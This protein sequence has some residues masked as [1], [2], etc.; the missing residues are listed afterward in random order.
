MRPGGTQGAAAAHGSGDGNGTG[1]GAD[2]ARREPALGSATRDEGTTRRS[3]Y[4]QPVIK[5]PVWAP[6]IPWYFF[7][8]GLG[9]ASGGLAYLAG[10]RGSETLA[11]RAWTIALAALSVSPVL[12]I[13][14]LGRPERFLHM[15][16]MFKVTSPMS[17]G[18]W[19][20]AGSGA[21]TAL[22]ALNV[23]TGRLGRLARVGRPAAAALG[24]PLATYTGALLAQTA[25]PAW[26]EA[27]RELPALFAAGAA[28]S[29]GAAATVLTPVAH[30]RPARRLALLGAATELMLVP[31]MERRLG[32][33]AE[34]YHDGPAGSYS[35]AAR[36]LTA[37]GAL[38][39]ATRAHRGRAAAM[40][41]GTLV[42]AG[43]V[44]ERWSVFKAG[45][46]SA[47]DPKYTVGPQRARVAGGGSRGASR[48]PVRSGPTA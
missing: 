10:L 38:L 25:V 27:R 14:D 4:G 30:A 28:A 9:G 48:R 34:P 15:L 20:L 7:F 33:L 3:Y 42:L 26:R 44:C 39:L 46:Q 13:K 8:G 36:G 29:A 21:T 18:S 2:T 31:L 5:D 17:V 1:T 19:V 47:R 12:L 32:E 43:A 40:A 24:L 16:R 6:E 23:A 41:A 35:R 45:F 11:R 22:A 37:S